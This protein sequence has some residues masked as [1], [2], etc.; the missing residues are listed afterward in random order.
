MT[1]IFFNFSFLII[2]VTILI[3]LCGLVH[4][5]GFKETVFWFFFFGLF[6][7]AP[8]AY[9]GSQ[10]RD[11]MGAV[12]AGLYHSHSNVGSKPCL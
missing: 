5:D 1:S 12:A 10:A 6:R 4:L 3:Y 8:M 7:P 11:Q 9:G 2:K